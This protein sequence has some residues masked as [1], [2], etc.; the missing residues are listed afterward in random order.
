M[1]TYQ[2]IILIFTLICIFI[3]ACLTFIPIGKYQSAYFK[4]IK[5]FRNKPQEHFDRQ[6]EY[7]QNFE[8]N[9]EPSKEFHVNKVNPEVQKQAEPQK[10]QKLK[11]KYIRDKNNP[12]ILHPYKP[13]KFLFFRF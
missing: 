11:P 4:F 8:E 1:K 9:Y 6:I 5:D 12:N 2:K 13:R 7:A 3:S 10:E